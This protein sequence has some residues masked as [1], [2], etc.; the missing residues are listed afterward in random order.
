MVVVMPDMMCSTVVRS[1]G[2]TDAREEID[3]GY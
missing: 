3:H 1:R 2:T